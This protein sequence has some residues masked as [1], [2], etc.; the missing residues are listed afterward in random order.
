M[1]HSPQNNRIGVSEIGQRE[2][3]SF[4]QTGLLSSFPI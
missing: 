2:Y 4:K 3:L 1:D